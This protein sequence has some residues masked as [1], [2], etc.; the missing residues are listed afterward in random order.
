MKNKFPIT[1]HFT[2]QLPQFKIDVRYI[3]KE[4]GLKFFEITSPIEFLGQQHPS[5]YYKLV[6]DLFCNPYFITMGLYIRKEKISLRE[7]RTYESIEKYTS[8]YCAD[9]SSCIFPSSSLPSLFLQIDKEILER[10]PKDET[11]ARI[12]LVKLSL[13]INDFYDQKNNQALMKKIFFLYGEKI[14]GDPAKSEYFIETDNTRKKFS[15]YL[16]NTMKS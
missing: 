3:D 5:F 16:K 12:Y 10:T 2:Y 13:A 6:H 8:S 1:V 15:L 7:I 14:D 9:V 11:L 4:L